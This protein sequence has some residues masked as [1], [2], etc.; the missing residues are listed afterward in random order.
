MMNAQGKQNF[1]SGAYPVDQPKRTFDYISSKIRFEG[2]NL[3]L[4]RNMPSSNVLDVV[5][6]D[7]ISSCMA[8]A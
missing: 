7:L 4:S 6:H 1:E 5:D 3:I 8:W 2:Q